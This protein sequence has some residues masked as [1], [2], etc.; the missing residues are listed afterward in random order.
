MIVVDIASTDET[1]DV[2]EQLERSHPQLHHTHTPA[3]ARDI[4][5]ER[6]ALTLGFRAARHEWVVL[7]RAD[8]EPATPHWLKHISEAAK[9]DKSIILGAAKYDEER[10]TWF[11]VKVAYCRLWNTLAYLRHVQDGYPAVRAD[12]CNVV[13]RRSLFMQA[14]GFGQHINLLAGAAELLVNRL[15]TPTNTAVITSPEA[16]VI[17]DRLPAKRLWLK[18]RTFYMET[19]RY[20]QH[21]TYYRFKQNLSMTM[22]WLMLLCII[23]FWPL[24]MYHNIPK[25]EPFWILLALLL[26]LVFIITAYN[27]SSFNRAARELGYKRQFYFSSPLLSLSLLIWNAQS[28][29]R[30]R[31]T[32]KNEFRKKFV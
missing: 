2:L 32:P 29:L 25:T 8:C 16:I 1:K 18:H 3:S 4:S 28:W 5:L 12:E 15:S 9:T 14:E 7:T 11:D 17:Q 24:T 21:A 22:P 19:R 6:L 31:F 30:H 27:T 10:R 13:I 23:G 26:L 20:Q